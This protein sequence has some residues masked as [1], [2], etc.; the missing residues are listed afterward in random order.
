MISD[1]SQALG[2]IDSPGLNSLRD[3]MLLGT[4]SLVKGRVFDWFIRES[5]RYP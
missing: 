5:A 3:A 2:H 1:I 4:P